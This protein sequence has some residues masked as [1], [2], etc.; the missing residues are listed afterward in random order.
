MMI[1]AAPA[2]CALFTRA[3]AHICADGAYSAAPACSEDDMLPARMAYVYADLALRRMLRLRAHGTPRSAATHDA[4]A[5]RAHALC[6]DDVVYCATMRR[7]D[8][9]RYMLMR[10]APV[11][12]KMRRR[13]AA[14]YSAATA[15]A[16]RAAPRHDML[17][18]ACY[19]D[20]YSRCSLDAD[21]DTSRRRAMFCH[22]AMPAASHVDAP[23]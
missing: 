8:D 21:A 18:C 22:S 17:R 4:T 19:K 3:D 2:R 5:I 15:S 11:R 16:E 23:R 20:V 9:T 12:T 13:D 7:G 10:H 6:H 1:C 14:V